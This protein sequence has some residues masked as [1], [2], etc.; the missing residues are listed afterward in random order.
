[1]LP[2]YLTIERNIFIF[3]FRV[4]REYS[5]CVD[6]TTDNGDIFIAVDFS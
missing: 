1:M 5:V 4:Y 2:R 3:S 6:V